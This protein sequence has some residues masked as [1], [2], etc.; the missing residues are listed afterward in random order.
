M[1]T[2]S[3]QRTRANRARSRRVGRVT[4]Y[5]RGKIWYI[6]YLEYKQ[7]IRRRV[8]PSADE[9]KRLAAQV[10]AQLATGVRAALSFEPLTLAGLRQSRI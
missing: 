3:R 7:R 1:P 2:T 6:Y 10:N 8:G 5:R 9:A 4:V